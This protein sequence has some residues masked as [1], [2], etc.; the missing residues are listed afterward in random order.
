MVI[1]HPIMSGKHNPTM[2]GKLRPAIDR[3][4]VPFHSTLGDG[5]LDVLFHSTVREYVLDISN[6]VV[7]SV[8]LYMPCL[9]RRAVPFHSTVG[10]GVLAV[11]NFAMHAMFVRRDVPN[12]VGV[13]IRNDFPKSIICCNPCFNM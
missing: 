5:V 7:D 1:I 12:P 2:G 13:S 3:R 11:P 4:D 6:L 10:D 8:L 9:V